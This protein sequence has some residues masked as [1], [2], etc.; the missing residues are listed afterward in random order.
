LVGAGAVLAIGAW[1]W[2]HARDDEPPPAR[3]D[4]ALERR[5]DDE[6]QRFET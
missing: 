2:S 1:R 6:L 5:L 3:L 4:P